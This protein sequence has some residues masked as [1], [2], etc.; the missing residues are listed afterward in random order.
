MDKYF[1]FDVKDPTKK[2]YLLN[3][4]KKTTGVEDFIVFSLPKSID[5]SN[6][7]LLQ[8]EP[9]Y[10]SEKA[11]GIRFYLILCM[12]DNVPSAFLVG[13][14][15]QIY[16]LKLQ[17]QLKLFQKLQIF[18]IELCQYKHVNYC[19]LVFDCLVHN[20]ENV[21]DQS[22]KQRLSIVKKYFPL[23]KISNPEKNL[24]K[25]NYIIASNEFLQILQ[26]QFVDIKYLN[27]FT[28]PVLDR[29]FEIDGYIFAPQ[30]RE[31][32]FSSQYL[33]KWKE[34]HTLDVLIGHDFEPYILKHGNLIKLK[35]EGKLLK[36]DSTNHDFQ[37]VF[38]GYLIHKRLFPE[39]TKPFEH[40]IECYYD[41]QYLQYIKIRPDKT[42][43]NNIKVIQQTLKTINDNVTLASLSF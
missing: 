10:I 1:L 9:Y 33:L 22:L 16:S 19:L 6:K 43:P 13:R 12:Y 28:K 21:C 30:N 4:I 31:L 41:G 17:G 2:Q 25:T 5:N 42:K 26:K 36:F 11:D 24:V 34:K 32:D 14:D 37:E 35:H 8:Q 18:D 7:Y 20:G 3:L 23:N 39:T 29:S 15:E 40:I 27:E 38:Q